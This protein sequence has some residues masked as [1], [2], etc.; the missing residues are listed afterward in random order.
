MKYSEIESLVDQAKT[1]RRQA[2]LCSVLLTSGNVTVH[3]AH[4]VMHSK[5]C[6]TEFQQGLKK[7]LAE[8]KER[9]EKILSAIMF[10]LESRGAS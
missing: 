2:D 6:S 8:E 7:L 1:A 4:N 10:N 3:D 5:L 9:N